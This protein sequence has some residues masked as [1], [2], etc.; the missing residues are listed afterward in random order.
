ME[1][2][3]T[4]R[5]KTPRTR[6]SNCR[7]FVPNYDI[8]NLGSIEKGYR[9]LCGQC[10]NAE[11]AKLGGLDKFEHLNFEPIRIVDCERQAHDFHFRTHLFLPGVALNAFELRDGEPAGYQFQIIGD[12]EEDLLALFGRL[13]EKIRRAL[14]I[15]HLKPGSLGLQVAGQ[16]VRGRI[17][18]DQGEEGR[19]PLLV[20]DGRGITWDHF[21]HMLMTFEGWQ[22]KLEILDKSEES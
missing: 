3:R 16:V 15:K 11:S 17:E 9:I 4:V 2:S 7:K 12:P 5:K 21:G 22:F 10:F 19:V 18:W 14:S 13:V 6:C 20:I 1:M 8:I